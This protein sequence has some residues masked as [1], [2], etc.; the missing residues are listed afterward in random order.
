M[1][2]LLTF[3]VYF[4]DR[5]WRDSNI[6]LMIDLEGWIVIGNLVVIVTKCA[7]GKK[8]VVEILTTTNF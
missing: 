2:S 8:T 4:C 5:N 7:F 6:L 3:Q 1:E